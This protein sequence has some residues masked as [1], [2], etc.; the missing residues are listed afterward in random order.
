MVPGIAGMLP[1]RV[2][3]QTQAVAAATSSSPAG[4]A[5][6]RTVNCRPVTL[7]T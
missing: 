1:Q 4:F 7:T 6:R 2:T 5:P 3:T